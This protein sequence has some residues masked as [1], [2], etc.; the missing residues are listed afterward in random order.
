M[1]DDEKAIDRE[2]ADII[3]AAWKMK[4]E[5]EQSHFES[6]QR[7]NRAIACWNEQTGLLLKKEVE[8][9]DLAPRLLD[10]EKAVQDMSRLIN[11]LYEYHEKQWEDVRTY[12]SDHMDRLERQIKSSPIKKQ[13][14][15]R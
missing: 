9:L 8:K 14:K 2:R 10:V 11:S 4:C 7:T 3:K 6:L 5:A 1:T 12:L 15:K 13:A